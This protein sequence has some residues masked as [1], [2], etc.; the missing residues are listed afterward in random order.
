MLQ[1]LQRRDSGT[2]DFAQNWDNYRNG[3]GNLSGEFWMG[4]EI[5]HRMTSGSYNFL[6]I[7]LSTF[8]HMYRFSMYS[9]FLVD[10]EATG[11]ALRIGELDPT[12]T[13]G[14][15]FTCVMYACMGVYI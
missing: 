4:N 11:Y 8:G 1:V 12:S 2:V 10:N 15:G 13:A 5:L 6:R 14:N 9:D 3:F 7:D